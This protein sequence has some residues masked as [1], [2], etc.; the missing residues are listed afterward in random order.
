MELLG[1]LSLYISQQLDSRKVDSIKKEE[2]RKKLAAALLMPAFE[3]PTVTS[4]WVKE[5]DELRIEKLTWNV[6]F[7]C[8]E[9]YLLSPSGAKEK[10]P[11]ILAL[12][13]HAGEKYWGKSKIVDI[14]EKLD[15]SLVEHQ[16]R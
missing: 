10:L 6:G 16:K 1:S 14:G 15:R 12:H 2:F 3:K 4:L 13:D 5:H 8:S 9:G 11:G 7:G